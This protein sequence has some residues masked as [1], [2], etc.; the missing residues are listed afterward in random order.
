MR[1]GQQERL[2]RA[3][4]ARAVGFYDDW[5]DSEVEHDEIEWM[6]DNR[7]IVDPPEPGSES[8]PCS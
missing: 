8:L 5:Q 1:I 7:Y 6:A 4:R 3:L 2:L